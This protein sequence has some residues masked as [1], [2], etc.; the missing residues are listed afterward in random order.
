VTPDVVVDIG[1]SRIKWGRCD[2]G[3]VVEMVA[4]PH[5]KISDW[6]RQ[7]EAWHVNTPSKWAIAGVVP[8]V[9]RLLDEWFRSRGHTTAVISSTLFDEDGPTDLT[10]TV[11]EVTMIGVDRLLTSLAAVTHAPHRGPVAVV[12]V[13]TAMT[14][15]LVT[16]KGTHVGGVI[17]PGPHL[18]ARSLN[19]YTAK[20][21]LIEI[22][23][24]RP[25]SIWGTNTEEAIEF[26]IANA[27]LG[28]ADQLIWDWAVHV[29]QPPWVFATGG[30]VGYLRGFE[31]TA[32]VAG[33][34]IDPMLTLEGI[35][36]AAEALP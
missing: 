3:R 20:L 21:P 12:N 32:E 15:D 22:D 17:L 23:P 6:E 10:T 31:F 34:V 33:F 29:G 14:I 1:N 18:M 8:T 9:V 16:K 2:D 26:G 35:R 7:A 5:E 4:F 36:I 30:D 24:V 27:V 11:D 13:G 28:A 25:F 19:N